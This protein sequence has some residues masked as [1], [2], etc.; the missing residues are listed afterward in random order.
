MA[1]FDFVPLVVVESV[2]GSVAVLGKVVVGAA[3]DPPV[4]V[5]DPP[6]VLVDCAKAT[7]VDKAAIAAATT[8]RFMMNNSVFEMS[9]RTGNIATKRRFQKI[10]ARAAGAEPQTRTEGRCIIHIGQRRQPFGAICV[11]I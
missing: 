3:D 9:L 7:P 10:R 5:D 6:D 2:P 1:E 8:S 11:R 4:V